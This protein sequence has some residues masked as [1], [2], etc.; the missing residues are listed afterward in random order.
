MTENDQLD[1]EYDFGTMT[2]H[3]M[4]YIGTSPSVLCQAFITVV[5][6]VFKNISDRT[7]KV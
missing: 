5:F 2:V 1:T 4:N 3:N 7:T 6:S